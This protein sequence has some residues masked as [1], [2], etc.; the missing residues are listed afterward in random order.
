M[1]KIDIF[2]NIVLDMKIYRNR[3]DLRVT[4]VIW[5][6]FTSSVGHYKKVTFYFVKKRCEGN[7][8]NKY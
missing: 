8:R 4:S 3:K 2:A 6:F 1:A 5:V 7:K